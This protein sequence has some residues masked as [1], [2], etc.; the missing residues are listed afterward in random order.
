MLR[1]RL[2]FMAR[3]SH[4]TLCDKV[5]QWLATGRE[6]SETKFYI[7]YKP[8]NPLC[9]KKCDKFTQWTTDLDFKGHRSDLI[10][11]IWFDYKAPPTKDHPLFRPDFR[12]TEIVKCYLF[13]CLQRCYPSN[14]KK[15]FF[16]EGKGLASLEENYNCTRQMHIFLPC[17]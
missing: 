5:Y 15:Q 13:I 4:T 16:S 10:I 9:L 14:K 12:Y 1:V 6:Y 17:N 11:N 2:S 7:N 3:C 8:V